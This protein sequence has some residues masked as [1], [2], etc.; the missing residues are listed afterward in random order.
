M[1]ALCRPLEMQDGQLG[2]EGRI[3]CAVPA[4]GAFRGDRQ[5]LLVRAREQ[6]VEL[7]ERALVELERRAGDDD[8]RIFEMTRVGR[9]RKI[10]DRLLDRLAGE[11]LAQSGGQRAPLALVEVRARGRL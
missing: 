10:V 6:L 2:R 5:R 1:S 9:G 3:R 7:L 8:L 4:R 11:L